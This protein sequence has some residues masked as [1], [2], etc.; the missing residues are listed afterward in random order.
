ME[1]GT[2]K[3]VY[4]RR[5]LL[6]ATGGTSESIKGLKAQEGIED[7]HCLVE[8]FRDRVSIRAREAMEDDPQS[9]S[10]SLVSCPH[11]LLKI[12]IKGRETA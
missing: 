3:P 11:N 4:Y 9:L 8:R 5:H 12:G 1:Y 10:S 7:I 2:D 6:Q